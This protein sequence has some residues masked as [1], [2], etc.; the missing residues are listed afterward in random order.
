MNNTDSNKAAEMRRDLFGRRVLYATVPTDINGEVAPLTAKEV[1][2]ALNQT[3]GSFLKNAEE[4]DYLYWYYKGNQPHNKKEIRPEI[5]NQITENRA[6]EMVEFKKG[7]EFSHPNQIVNASIRELEDEGKDNESTPVSYLNSC[8]RVDGKEAKDAALAEWFY[9]SGT[10]YRLCLPL[11]REVTAD[12]SPYYTSVLD[13]RQTFVIYA[14]DISQKSIVGGRFVKQ[15]RLIDGEHR[16]IWVLGAYTESGYFTWEFDKEPDGETDFTELS[17]TKVK[18]TLGMIP[19]IEYP[20]NESRMGY[21]EVC[22][23]LYDAINAVSSN[24]INA[25]EQFVQALLVFLNC[26]PGKDDDGKYVFPKSGD[27]IAVSGREGLPADVKYLVAQLNQS[28]TQVAKED[29]INAA[30]EICGVPSNS[31]NVSGG[32][33]GQAIYYL[34]DWA[35]AEARA[36]STEK[37]FKRAEKEYLR[38]VLKIC[39]DTQISSSEIGDLTLHDID[40]NF[41]RNRNENLLVKTQSLQTLQQVGIHPEDAIELVELFSDP[42]AAYKKSQPYLEQAWNKLMGT[43]QN[44]ANA[45]GESVSNGEILLNADSDENTDNT[46]LPGSSQKD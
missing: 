39:R 13:P 7:Y 20:L 32:N 10:S 1:A 11:A 38:I 27:G 46:E 9:I 43:G 4:T 3:F 19:I 40:V 5:D 25:I 37:V 14:D 17:A 8:A 28:D 12:D 41:T 42:S 33:T 22:V 2:L 26:E 23:P 21:V 29:L 18:N 36:K 15:K 44:T 16:D 35:T 31:K 45:F 30:N 34:E 6:F 24:R